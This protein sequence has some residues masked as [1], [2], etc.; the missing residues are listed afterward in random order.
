[1]SQTQIVFGNGFRMG[2]DINRLDHQ[3]AFAQMR[4]EILDALNRNTDVKTKR[5]VIDSLDRFQEQ[6]EWDFDI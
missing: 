5:R 1:M 4:V 6:S 2:S 3:R